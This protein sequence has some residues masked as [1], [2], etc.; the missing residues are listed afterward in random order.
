MKT[1]AYRYLGD[2]RQDNDLG[3]TPY[4]SRYFAAFSVDRH[5]LGV[6]DDEENEKYQDGEAVDYP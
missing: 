4:G 6:A 5:G 2:N 3:D 1:S